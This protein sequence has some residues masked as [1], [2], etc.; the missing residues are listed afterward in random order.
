MV[1]FMRHLRALAQSSNASVLVIN[2][3]TSNG[4]NQL[5]PNA[6]FP[7]TRKPALGP[8]FPFLTDATLWIT[9]RDSTMTGCISHT[10]EI[11]RSK[12]TSSKRWCAFRSQNGFLL[13]PATPTL[14]GA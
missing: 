14:E 8:S 9:R 1:G 2:D 12:T 3:S 10:A 7:T 4:N 6:V 11:W 5:N 13:P